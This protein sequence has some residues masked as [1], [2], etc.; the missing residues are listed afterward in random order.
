MAKQELLESS[1]E[2]FQKGRSEV[3]SVLKN[4]LS[5]SH[6]GHAEPFDAYFIKKEFS[7]DRAHRLLYLILQK[8]DVTNMINEMEEIGLPLEEKNT[9]IS[10]IDAKINKLM[11]E[12]KK[13]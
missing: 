11:G 12:L 13:V 3:L 1:L 6:K 5:S 7:D 2:G 4:H 10:E 8:S 9:R